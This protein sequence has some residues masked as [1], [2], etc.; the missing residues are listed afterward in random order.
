M[1]ITNIHNAKTHFSKYLKKVREGEEVII[2][3]SN[4][5]I[6]KLVAYNYS[7]DKRRAN[8]FK[9]KITINKDFDKLPTDFM[10]F[11]IK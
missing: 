2:C 9:G 6:A 3:T 4:K 1:E 11:F 5:P 7:S 10:H 8:L